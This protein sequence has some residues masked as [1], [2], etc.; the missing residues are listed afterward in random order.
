[1]GERKWDKSA[2]FIFTFEAG[3]DLGKL[4]CQYRK[5]VLGN[6]PDQVEID[7]K[8]FV[9]GNISE[10]NDIAPLDIRIGLL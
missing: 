3:K 4:L 2:E 6:L 1:M 5:V 10:P 7:A 8:I 9:N